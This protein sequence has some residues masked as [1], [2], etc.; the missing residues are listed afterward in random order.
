MILAELLTEPDEGDR[1]AVGEPAHSDAGVARL[2]LE[3]RGI[4]FSYPDGSE[5]LRDV[6]VLID[7]VDRVVGQEQVDLDI[8]VLGNESGQRRRRLFSHRAATA[9]RVGHLARRRHR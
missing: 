5:V 3:A 6:D 9:V 2:P 1:E 8:R 4:S 7:Q